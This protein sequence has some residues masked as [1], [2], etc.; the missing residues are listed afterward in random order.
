MKF[1]IYDYKN[2]FLDGS[3]NMT[4]SNLIYVGTTKT[5]ADYAY[6]RPAPAGSAVVYAEGGDISPPY[7]VEF[8]V[9][10]N[11]KKG[12][13]GPD[14]DD[15][16]PMTFTVLGAPAEKDDGGKPLFDGYGGPKVPGDAAFAAVGSL[17]VPE[18]EDALSYRVAVSSNRH[19]WFKATVS[20]GRASAHLLRG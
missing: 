2:M 12:G 9:T 13:D 6:M 18:T 8:R 4:A 15:P 1:S 16:A 20:G 10:A 7:F 3:E 19:K 17:T 11:S 14:K 5:E